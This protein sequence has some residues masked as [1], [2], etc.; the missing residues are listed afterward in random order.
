[1]RFYLRIKDDHRSYGVLYSRYYSGWPTKPNYGSIASNKARL[2]AELINRHSRLKLIHDGVKFSVEAEI[3]GE[4]EDILGKL[5]EIERRFTS[6]IY[7]RLVK[8][9]GNLEKFKEELAPFIL[10]LNLGNS[11]GGH[12]GQ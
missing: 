5:A 1:M 8:V 11:E 3:S 12:N 4:L 7:N 10:E 2:A 9:T 6:T